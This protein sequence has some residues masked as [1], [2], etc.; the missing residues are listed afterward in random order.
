MLETL[1]DHDKCRDITHILGAGVVFSLYRCMQ[2]DPIGIQ[3]GENSTPSSDLITQG[4]SR[5]AWHR[6]ARGAADGA[7]IRHGLRGFYV[8]RKIFVENFHLWTGSMESPI[9]IV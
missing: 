7:N 4:C 3:R 9:P 5:R 1:D 2:A 8:K 6:T